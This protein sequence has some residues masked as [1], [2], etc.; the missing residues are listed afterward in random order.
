MTEAGSIGRLR[1]SYESTLHSQKLCTRLHQPPL[2]VIPRHLRHHVLRRSQDHRRCYVLYHCRSDTVLHHGL[3][4]QTLDSQYNVQDEEA[5]RQN[6]VQQM[7]ELTSKVQRLEEA[8]CKATTDYIIARRD[9]QSADACA[10]DATDAL[11]TEKQASAAKV[12]A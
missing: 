2:H 6:F 5:H 4:P 7:A 11:A 12:R 1:Y 9:K 10:A 3:A 8:L